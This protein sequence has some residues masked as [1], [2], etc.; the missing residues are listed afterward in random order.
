MNKT[1]LSLFANKNEFHNWKQQNDMLRNNYR[2]GYKKEYKNKTKERSG[3][4]NSRNLILIGKDLK[5]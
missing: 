3:W 1:N 4:A 2:G 5:N